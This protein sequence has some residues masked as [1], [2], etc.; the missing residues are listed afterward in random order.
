MVVE[1]CAGPGAVSL[2]IAD[3][4]TRRR[5]HAVELSEDAAATRPRNLAGTAVGLQGDMADALPGLNGTVDLVIANPPY[6]PLEAY[7]RIPAEVRDHDPSLALFSG[8]GRAGRA[9]GPGRGSRPAAAARRLGLRRARR[10][11]A[12]VGVEVFV[13]QGGFHR[14]RDHPDLNGRPGR[15]ARD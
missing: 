9:Q 12:R 5:V 15:R 14:V 10:G 13:G 6:V 4:V 2:A 1:L 8:R 11:S 3:R 7:A